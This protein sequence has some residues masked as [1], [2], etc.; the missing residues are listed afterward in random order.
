MRPEKFHR[1]R[2][3]CVQSCKTVISE[4]SYRVRL[5]LQP[6]VLVKIIYFRSK[7]TILYLAVEEKTVA[8]QLHC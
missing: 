7:I 3:V 2:M 6:F 8:G 4:V 5:I 1:S